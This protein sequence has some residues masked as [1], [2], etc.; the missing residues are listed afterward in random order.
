[1][2]G[3]GGGVIHGE[4]HILKGAMKKTACKGEMIFIA[5]RKERGFVVERIHFY[6]GKKITKIEYSIGQQMLFTH[7][8]ALYDT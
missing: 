6:F 2:R 3:R 7:L 4:T 8:T 5:R 1:M